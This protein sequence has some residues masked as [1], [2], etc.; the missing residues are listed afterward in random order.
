MEHPKTQKFYCLTVEQDLLGTWCVKKVYGNLPDKISGSELLLCASEHD[1][2]LQLC[3]L[4]I[5][6]RKH[7]YVYSQRESQYNE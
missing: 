2:W 6:K 4:E 5:A 3:D 1:A 7:G